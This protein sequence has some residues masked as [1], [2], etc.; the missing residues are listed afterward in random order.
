MIYTTAIK[1]IDQLIVTFIK[2]NTSN[3]MCLIDT[4]H[5]QL[6]SNSIN[7]ETANILKK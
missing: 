3:W 4:G 2:Q 1:R 5:I 7:N 6:K